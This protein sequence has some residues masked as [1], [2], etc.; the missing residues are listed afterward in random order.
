MI[1][2][3]KIRLT[4][5]PEQ[6]VYFKKASGTARFVYNW[7]LAQW[8]TVHAA[9]PGIAYGMMAA[10][11]EFNR[12]KGEQFPWI[13]DVA[14]DVCEGA[15]ANLGAA[16]K[17]YFNGKKG[18]RK[19]EKVGFP[20]FKS[21]K[22]SKQ[23][24]RLNN[25]KFTVDGHHLRIPN[26][27]WVNM[28]EELRFQGKIMGAVVSKVAD[29]WFVSITVEVEKPAPILW[30]KESIGVDLGVKTLA[31]LSG[32]REFENQKL[33]RSELNK[34]CKLNRSLAR[35][36]Q[37]SNR[38]HKAKRRLG[39]FHKR[40]SDRRCDIT[41][42]MTTTIAT[43]YCTVGVEDLNVKGMGKSRRLSLSISDASLSDI[44]RQL[45]YKAEWF[46]GQV[47]K[48]GRFFASS[49]MCSECGHVNKDLKLSDRKW[50]CQG[51][52]TIH[53]RDWNAS[54]NIER[55]ALRLVNV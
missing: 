13:Y 16:L 38:W 55:E 53:D 35:R 47:V 4:P 51:C 54:K 43:T 34:L 44:L 19:G 32:G 45:A 31:T 22:R 23:S 36:N 41:H 15:F 25:D 37:G 8:Q 9:N 42:K 26:L 18:Q 33:L 24:F 1:R 30:E 48:V 7:A 27:G 39:R 49:K 10:K 11:K 6:E 21:K 17:N 50:A 12:L 40:I 28:A 3:H 46:G 2:A 29:W 5:T 14:K 20:K 52:R